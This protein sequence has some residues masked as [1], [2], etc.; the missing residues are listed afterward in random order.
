MPV[1]LRLP[2]SLLPACCL[3]AACSG[4][5]PV[6]PALPPAPSQWQAGAQAP[7]VAMDDWWQ[8]FN[9]PVLDALVR[10]AQQN[11]FDLAAAIARVEQ[12]RAQARVAGA[13]GLP[14][15]QLGLNA[16]RE[17]LMHG[18]GYSAIDTYQDDP[19]LETYSLG[20]SASYEVDFWGGVRARAA[21]AVSTWQA[22]LFDQSALRLSLEADVAQAYLAVRAQQA[23]LEVARQ[24][25]K[26]AEQVLA[27]VQ[28][29][30][31]AGAATAL[32]L[33][34]QRGLT[35]RQR[36]QQA[37]LHQQA[38]NA[39]V[40][41]ATLLGV[42]A[43]QLALPPGG[44]EQLHW[45]SIGAGVPSQ[46]LTRRPDVAR[47]EAR[48]AAAD[49]DVQVARA[50]MLPRLTLT[51]SLAGGA[52]QAS[53]LLLNRYYDVGGA[54][55]APIFNAGALRAQHQASQARRE[56]LLAGYRKAVVDAFAD[57]D[58]ALNDAQGL[59]AQ[60][61]W[62]EEALAQARTTFELAERRYR[63][64]AESLLTMLDAQRSL[65]E[66]QDTGIQ[67]RLAR[68]NASVGLYK[69][70]GGGWQQRAPGATPAA[71]AQAS[72]DGPPTPTQD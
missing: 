57:T 23:R 42:A 44:F 70:L 68:L 38:A 56:E 36:Q 46:L 8:R 14:T 49:A 45:P 22:S 17:R 40:T 30:H 51:A 55:L 63:A 41:L 4:P 18:P 20:L 65:F 7:I 48:L 37:L 59:D 64:G 43:G 12:A 26:N 16:T 67:L 71:G 35:A 69:A 34:Q 28:T 9:D 1:H 52:N 58:R 25:L 61:G 11:S 10:R 15:V 29:R 33:A 31:G 54:L 62:Q 27:L 60:L 3:L 6:P 2:A 13:A 47:A 50:M 66:A 24:N 32:E 72:P 39:E 53:D 21:S 19:G 5:A